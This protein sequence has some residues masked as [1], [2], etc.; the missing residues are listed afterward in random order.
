MSAVAAT[1]AEVVQSWD[2]LDDAGGEQEQPSSSN[3]ATD[4]RAP[5]EPVASPD[6]T[7]ATSE[8]PAGE[9]K[10]E[11]AERLAALES[12]N[13][14]LERQMA[15]REWSSEG[16]YR[17]EQKKNQLLQ[18]QLQTI[19]K[20]Y[21]D[22]DAKLTRT[23]DAAIA[24]AQAEDNE[25]G[26]RALQAEKRAE[27]LQRQFDRAEQQRTQAERQATEIASSTHEWQV[28]YMGE[29]V[30][31]AAIPTLQAEAA[32]L[33][34]EYELSPE[35]TKDL[36][37]VVVTDDLRYLTQNAPPDVV[38]Q[39]TYQRFEMLEQRATMLRERQVQANLRNAQQ[40]GDFTR[41]SGGSGAGRGDLDKAF[42]E[43]DFEDALAMVS[44]GY[45]PPS[46]GKRRR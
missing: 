32:Q 6:T 23:Y 25:I 8:A 39:V 24:R 12:R 4:Q 11:R 29:Q 46:K 22:E 10:D 45:V 7:V 37:S 1:D 5:D 34:S 28:R 20:Q 17:A 33:A 19:S 42:A 35:D 2:D 40:N 21:E 3:T 41:E 14:E 31:Q 38:A 16:R 18:E 36:L 43:A 26:A 30:R 9:T 15:A 44:E 27:L 13:A